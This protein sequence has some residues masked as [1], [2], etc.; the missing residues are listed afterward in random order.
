MRRER[1]ARLAR[2]VFEGLPL[3]PGK[4]GLKSKAG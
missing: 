3:S 2:T 1:T 4:R